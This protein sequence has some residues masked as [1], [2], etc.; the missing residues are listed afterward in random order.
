MYNNNRG[1]QQGFLIQARDIMNLYVQPHVSVGV[2]GL[3]AGFGLYLLA[4]RPALPLPRGYDPGPV[5]LGWLLLALAVASAVAARVL[6]ARRRRREGVWRSPE[7]LQRVADGLADVPVVF[8][9][10]RKVSCVITAWV[11]SSVTSHHAVASSSLRGTTQR[12]T[13]LTAP[14]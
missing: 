10:I 14:L 13:R 9:S 11:K 4:V 12:P 3:V 8:M 6:A 7:H 1:G 2:P 5:R